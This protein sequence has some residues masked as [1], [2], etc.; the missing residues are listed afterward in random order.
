MGGDIADNADRLPV[1]QALADGPVISRVLGK[2]GADRADMCRLVG[3]GKAAVT[4][5]AAG[6]VYYKVSVDAAAVD[7]KNILMVNI[8]AGAYTQFAQDAAIE[9]DGYICM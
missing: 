2:D 6:R 4:E 7:R 5:F 8:P 1:V 3:R 9:V